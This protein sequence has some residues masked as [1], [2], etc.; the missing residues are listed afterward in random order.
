MP[1]LRDMRRKI[2]AVKSTEK[3]TNTMKL[4]SAAKFRR[5]QINILN[6]RPY[7]YRMAEVMSSLALRA[8][9]GTHKLLESKEEN[10]IL[11]MVV[12]SDRGLCGAFNSNIL[13]RFESI[14]NELVGQGKSVDIVAVGRKARDFFARRGQYKVVKV[15]TDL[16]LKNVK[17]EDVCLIADYL[18]EEFMADHYDA[19][20]ALYNEFKSA[21]K[22]EIIFEKLIPI[23]PMEVKEQT[24]KIDFIYEPSKDGILEELLPLHLRTQVY[25]IFL[26]SSA[27][28]HGA[29][30]TAMDNATK[31]A[32]ELIRK[33]TL[34]Y[35]KAR[36]A[37][38]TK[39]LLEIVAGAEALNA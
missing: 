23:K 30:M 21:I 9:P 31:N 36:Q 22:Q 35:N 33:L 16:F 10:R 17:Y 4:V 26:E 24:A 38:I 7:A 32:G 8:E 6:L 1:S 34:E 27:S 18:V 14:Y 37:S 29:R 2:Q 19:V 20:Y 39:E 15:F 25:R 11:V 13:R 3:I 28:E 5:A 12:T